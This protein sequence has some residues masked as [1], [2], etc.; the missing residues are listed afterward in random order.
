MYQNFNEE[1]PNSARPL[2]ND[3]DQPEIELA[4]PIQP[5]QRLNLPNPR[6]QNKKKVNSL[7]EQKQQ[8]EFKNRKIIEH[9]ILKRVVFRI[10]LLIIYLFVL[11][12]GFIS[13]YNYLAFIKSSEKVVEKSNF[14]FQIKNCKLQIFDDFKSEKSLSLHF[15]IPG[16]FDFW[17][18]EASS[19]E[20]NKTK[21]ES[22]LYT[23]TYN[24]TNILSQ[25]SCDIRMHLGNSSTPLINNLF[26]TCLPGSDCSIISYSDKFEVA[27]ST[28]I[29][30]NEV[31][32]NL[33][34]YVGKSIFYESIYGLA[35]INDFEISEKSRLNLTNGV[36]VIQSQQNY[37]INWTSGLPSYCVSAPSTS[38]PIVTGCKEGKFKKIIFEEVTIKEK[39]QIFF[40]SI[41]FDFI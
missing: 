5:R 17:L 38:T 16:S 25:E 15:S 13:I 12:F 3:R 2:V 6:I 14:A 9:A 8:T 36:I 39:K 10:L 37:A 11:I 28:V 34:K 21:D 41:D 7:Q 30:G 19:F 4:N 26:I 32:L 33:K 31:E 40:S 27:N 24:I 35:Q 1:D 22:G 23:Y 20:S 18:D 29:Q